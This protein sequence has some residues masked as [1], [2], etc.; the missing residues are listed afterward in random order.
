MGKPGCDFALTMRDGQE[1]YY[2]L[3][4]LVDF[5]NYPPSYSQSDIVYL[6]VGFVPEKHLN[7]ADVLLG[8]HYVWCLYDEP[9]DVALSLKL[10]QPKG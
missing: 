5:I 4:N 2:S 7:K 9:V 1:F 6:E 8:P 10:E 3:G